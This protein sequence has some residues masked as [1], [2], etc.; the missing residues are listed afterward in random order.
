MAFRPYLLTSVRNAFYDRTRKDKRV[1]VTDEVPEDLG[2]VLAI[3]ARSD[4]DEERR[5]A[6]LAYAS[7]PERWQLVLWHTEVEGMSPAE[8][9]PL[10]GLA[11]NAVAALAYRA[12]EGL[13]QAY[14]NAHVQTAL[15]ERCAEIVPK[16]GA[17]VRDDLSNRDRRKVEEHLADC[18]RCPAIVAELQEA[19]SRLRV[20]LI[21]IV[22]GIPAAAYLSGIGGG[23]GGLVGLGAKVGRRFQDLGVGGQVASVVA[24]AAM[25]SVLVVGT[26]AI[27][28]RIGDQGSKQ[29]VTETGPG[30]GGGGGGSAP[31]GSSPPPSRAPSPTDV[32]PTATPTVPGTGPAVTLPPPATTGPSV[33]ATSVTSGSSTSTATATSTSATTPESTSETTANP[34]TLPPT[35]P[36]TA[37]TTTTTPVSAAQLSVS[38]SSASPAYAGGSA[39]LQ[40]SVANAAAVASSERGLGLVRPDVAPDIPLTLVLPLPP[41]TSFGSVDD[42]AW[43][44]TSA[45]STLTCHLPA[46]AEGAS[47]DV[48]LQVAIAPSTRGT[49]TLQATISD[50]SNQSAIGPVPP[51][52]IDIQP[53]PSG[54]GEVVVDR[55]DLVLLGNAVLTCNPHLVVLNCP[56]ARDKPAVEPSS[57]RQ[58]QDMLYVDVDVDALTVNSSSATL[59]VPAGGEVLAA[60]LLWGGTVEAGPLGHA[61]PR[62][63]ELGTVRLTAPGAKQVAV[64]ATTIK[65]DPSFPLH[66]VASADVTGLVASAGGGS[67][68]VADIQVGTGFGAFGG[69]AL[70]VIVRDPAAPL[71]LI[72]LSDEIA[73]LH[74]SDTVTVSL[75]DVAPSSADRSATVA[76]A[77]FEGDYGIVPEE[78]TFNGRILSNAG[79]A[80]NNPLNGSITTPGAR[81]PTYVNNFGFDADEFAAVLKAGESAAELVITTKL[82][83]GRLAGVAFSIPL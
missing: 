14:L 16:L 69:W 10:L 20:A 38:L 79:N 6:A 26:V 72:A 49:I 19:G 2:Q 5:M 39:A 81:N 82:D 17:Y 56:T 51:L 13:R 78:L 80:T 75:G 52:V 74:T 3:A 43:A 35:T 55:A 76:F 4:E 58:L 11:P 25:A 7:L 67:Y 33:A 36:T 37:G 22:A 59:G 30:G 46:P 50:G 53:M 73:T 28:H 8:I 71:R 12:R 45:A 48:I 40:V 83:R 29:A 77:A 42:A 47:T 32:P 62:P 9:G 23:A 27:A 64:T 61:A 24:A 34:T 15:P 44:C 54:I 60:H 18:D 21:P 65:P 68:T 70:E 31:G 66:Y 57:N 41:G 1:D 63:K